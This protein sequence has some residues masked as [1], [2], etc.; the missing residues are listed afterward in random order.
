MGDPG[1]EGHERGVEFVCQADVG[2]VVDRQV[3]PVAPCC[4]CDGRVWPE[5]DVEV[6]QVRVGL[7]ALRPPDRPGQL[8]PANDVATSN[9]MRCGATR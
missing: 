6:Q 9:G 7:L 4:S 5:L 1:V 8:L 3:V 2:G